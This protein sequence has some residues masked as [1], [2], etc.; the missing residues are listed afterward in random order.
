MVCNQKQETMKS[1]TLS[2]LLTFSAAASAADWPT[3]HGGP[4]RTGNAD[5]MAG[6]KSPNKL[7]VIKEKEQFIGSP[8][9]AGDRI[10]FG[11]VGALGPGVIR[12]VDAATG[13]E[14]WK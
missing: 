12:C 1:L 11:S 9:A 7:W 3:W 4:Q 5:G 13:K 2:F 8:S 14:I 6:P 10:I